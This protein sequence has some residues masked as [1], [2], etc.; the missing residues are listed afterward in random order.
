M[1][2]ND[3]KL[4]IHTVRRG[5]FVVGLSVKGEC[6]P[7]QLEKLLVVIAARVRQQLGGTD[8]TNDVF[9][10]AQVTLNER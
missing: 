10:K 1:N 9:F 7:E 6:P 2:D 8:T 4:E 5:G 3:C